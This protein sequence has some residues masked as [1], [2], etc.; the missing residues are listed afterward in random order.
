VWAD[1]DIPVLAIGWSND[2]WFGN[3][4]NNRQCDAYWGDRYDA[5]QI[6]LQGYGHGTADDPKAVMGV[7]NFLRKFINER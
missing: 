6:V 3:R 2:P 7:E 4:Y 1:K 5:T